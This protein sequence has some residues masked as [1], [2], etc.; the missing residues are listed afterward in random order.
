MRESVVEDDKIIENNK[1]TASIL[2]EFF[3]NIIAT[4]EI[5]QYNETEPASHNIG[6]PLMKA[7][8]T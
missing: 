2:N 6:D 3:S 4:L 1:N 5:P 7:I 8:M